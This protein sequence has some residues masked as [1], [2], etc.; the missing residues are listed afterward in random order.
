MHI[1]I[2]QLTSAINYDRNKKQTNKKQQ[3]QQKLLSIMKDNTK[4]QY[5]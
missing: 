1:K 4:H 5:Y 3:Q 2:A